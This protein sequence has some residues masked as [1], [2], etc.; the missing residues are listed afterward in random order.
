MK[1]SMGKKVKI[2]LGTFLIAA[3]SLGFIASND[4]DFEIAKNLDIFV[5]MFRE[6]NTLYVDNVTPKKLINAGIEGMLSS[7]DPYTTYIPEEDVDEFKFMTTGKYGG[8]G[9]LI[10]K[11]GE[12]TM[13]SEPYEGFPAQR[14]GLR[15]GD[16][17]ISIDNISTKNKSISEVSELL[18]GTPNTALTLKIKRIGN[19]SVLTK[20]FDREQ[21]AIPNVP[22]YGMMQGDIGYILLN[23]F[24]KNAAKE[25]KSAFIDLKSQ[26]AKSIILD[27]RGNPGGLLDEAVN[28]SNIWISRKKE[29]VSTKGKNTNW[30]K[31]YYTENAA[32]D[33]TMPLVLLVNRGSA[34]ASE[35]VAG[36]LQDLD[37]AIIIGQRTFGKGLVQ[38]TRPLSYNAHLKLTTA[39]YYIPSGRCIQA[40][41]YSHRN[42]DG[43]VGHIPDSLISAF[44]TKNGRT[45]YD[46][47]GIKPDIK[48]KSDKPGN[49][50]IALYAKNLIFDFATLF[51]S[52]HKE[53]KNPSDFVITDDI[54][55]EFKNFITEKEFKYNTQSSEKLT[56]L[57]KTAKQEG[58][59]DVIK[60]D[61]SSLEEHL[62]GDKNK[63]LIT[64][65]DEIKELLRNEIVSR[66]FFQKGRIEANIKDDPEVNKAVEILNQDKVVSEIL[67]GTYIGETVYAVSTH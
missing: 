14:S 57:I 16:T 50:T 8:I 39:K 66:Y 29:I 11:A 20:S 15:A 26:G 38:T 54:Y 28:I 17:I 1:F 24:M 12:Y 65:G 44:K 27:L 49:I 59:Y 32:V 43:S 13:I 3:F 19:D 33:T 5:T 48:I 53:I 46:G 34:S 63:D 56:D 58:Y 64:F 55:N 40:L 7:L 45:V 23:N 6:I 30:D 47:G 35:I 42:E 21:V 52:Q 4:T 31:E 62:H 10:R 51:A 25:V 22:Y 37:R 36:S 60:D 67:H 41:D 18:K 61:L 9:A 2:L